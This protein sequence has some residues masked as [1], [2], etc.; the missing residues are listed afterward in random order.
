[1][2]QQV[3]LTNQAACQACSWPSVQ[4]W[5]GTP[6]VAPFSCAG[7]MTALPCCW[8]WTV[9]C[10]A[11]PGACAALV[12][13]QCFLGMYRLA[14][15]VPPEACMRTCWADRPAVHK[16]LL[17]CLLARHDAFALRLMGLRIFCSGWPCRQQQPCIT[18][19]VAVCACVSAQA[20]KVYTTCFLLKQ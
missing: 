2:W 13:S 8:P 16:F 7:C 18:S 10:C 19:S 20:G 17:A 5:W 15:Q 1:M 14:S 6:L 3:S 12:C 9:A 4:R 11:H